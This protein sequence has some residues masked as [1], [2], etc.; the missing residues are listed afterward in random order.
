MRRTQQ[1]QSDEALNVSSPLRSSSTLRPAASPTRLGPHRDDAAFASVVPAEVGAH[2]QGFSNAP[3]RIRTCD[4]RIR[5]CSPEAK[6]GG[7]EPNSLHLDR[8][9]GGHNCRVGDKVRDKVVGLLS[10]RRPREMRASG[11]APRIA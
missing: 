8:L 2:L 7:V 9:D 10:H 5:S 3:G 6:F 4:P 1:C 11:L